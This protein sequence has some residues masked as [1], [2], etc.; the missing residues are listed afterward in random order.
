[1]GEPT[2]AICEQRKA[3]PNRLQRARSSRQLFERVEETTLHASL[4]KDGGKEVAL[5]TS[6]MRRICC[7]TGSH[8]PSSRDFFRA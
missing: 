8:L 5:L 1:M 2:S 4:Q 7:L 3:V 6:Q